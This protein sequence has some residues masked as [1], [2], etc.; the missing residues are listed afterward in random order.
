MCVMMA[1]RKRQCEGCFYFI[2]AV[3]TGSLP[4]RE[5]ETSPIY[6]ANLIRIS[7]LISFFVRDGAISF[8]SYTV[9]YT[10]Y[11][12]PFL[13]SDWPCVLKAACAS[14]SHTCAALQPHNIS[15]ELLRGR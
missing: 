5:A 15:P 3:T 13:A 10:L 4:P 1:M 7:F 2:Q 8:L 9:S 6:L 11:E 12:I 14:F